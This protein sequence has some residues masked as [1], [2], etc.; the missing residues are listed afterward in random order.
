M[1]ITNVPITV[2]HA[3]ANDWNHGELV[4]T[5]ICNEHSYCKDGDA[6]NVD[7]GDHS[8]LPVDSCPCDHFYS[9]LPACVTDGY[10]SALE[11]GRSGGTS[12]TDPHS[13]QVHRGPPSFLATAVNCAEQF[14]QV[15]FMNASRPNCMGM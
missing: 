1:P 7:E 11:G 12:T 5:G 14:G 2:S 6:R 10:Q 9:P 4:R 15:T 13:G 8:H 3:M